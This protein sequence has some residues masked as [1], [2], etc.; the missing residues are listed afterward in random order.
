[1]RKQQVAAAESNMDS[2]VKRENRFS[3]AQLLQTESETL[4][5]DMPHLKFDYHGLTLACWEL[6]HTIAQN[7]RRE[8]RESHEYLFN[9]ARASGK[10]NVMDEVLWECVALA[11]MAQDD[12]TH[13]GNGDSMLFRLVPAFEKFIKRLNEMDS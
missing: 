10:F 1:M 9:G 2:S 13:P 3:P 5:A 4:A 11:Q 6:N 7:Y 12:E 8:L